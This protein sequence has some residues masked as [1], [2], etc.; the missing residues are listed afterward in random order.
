MDKIWS[1]T[2]LNEY[3]QGLLENAPLLSAVWIQGEISNYKHHTSGHMYFTLKDKESTVRAVMFRGKNRFLSFRPE[4]GLN[5]IIRGQVSVYARDGNYQI[6]VDEMEPAGLGGIFL[7]LEQTKR[8][9]E[10]DGLFA[11]ERKR[12]LPPLPRKV[13]IVTAPTGAAIRDLFAVIQRRFPAMDILFSPAI[14]QGE[15][16]VPSLLRALQRLEGLPDVDVVIIGRGGGSREDLW[17]FNDEALCRAIAAFPVPVISAVG[18]ESDVS[19]SDLVA[20]V[21]AA[22]PSAAAELA[23]PLYAAL[24]DRVNELTI[25]LQRTMIARLERARRNVASLENRPSL[26]QPLHRLRVPRQRVDQF[27]ERLRRVL[28]PTRLSMMRGRITDLEKR[29]STMGAPQRLL[30]RR[31]RLEELQRQLVM[32][33]QKGL[34]ERRKELALQ[35]SLLDALS[36]LAVLD[37]GFSLCMDQDGRVVRDAKEIA[38][39]DTVDIVLHRGELACRV[40]ERRENRRWQI[41]RESL[42]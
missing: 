15:E 8:R 24:Q 37:R 30:P 22:T 41:K 27:E 10:A 21:R 17:A 13:G 20:D 34:Q 39:G 14:V 16:A 23:V 18:H 29:L 38:P 12:P 2:Q 19:L 35:A 26:S 25:Q 11:Q 42:D 33:A 5:V 6:Y 1:V 3:I 40:E 9:L 32:I 7:A 36:P 31:Q 4:N 28:S